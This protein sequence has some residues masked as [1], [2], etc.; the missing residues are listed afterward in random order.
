MQAPYVPTPVT[1]DSLSVPSLNQQP[2]PNGTY[3]LHVQ[4]NG[5]RFLVP[6]VVPLYPPITFAGAPCFR[7]DLCLRISPPQRLDLLSLLATKLQGMF[8]PDREY[9]ATETVLVSAVPANR[10]QSSEAGILLP[11]LR[12][13]IV[14]QVS[15]R[16][17][18]DNIPA[19][20]KTAKSLRR[21]Y[22]QGLHDLCFANIFSLTRERGLINEDHA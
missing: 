12:S 17:C 5:E 22:W 20:G 13:Y 3:G 21:H 7:D 2:K 1:T 6:L 9:G 14:R 16:R 11:A 18:T 15:A 10:L 19:F 4:K 8:R